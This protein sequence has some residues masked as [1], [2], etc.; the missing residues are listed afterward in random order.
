MR[1]RNPTLALALLALLLVPAGARADFGLAP[2]KATVTTLNRDG[3]I[4]LQAGSHPYSFNLHFELNTDASGISEGGAAR[5]VIVDLPAGLIGN[6]RAVPT[7]P[8]QKFEG[9]VAKCPPSTQVGVLRGVLPGISEAVGPLYNLV[10]P[11][12]TAAQLGFTS[13]TGLESLQS[14]SLRP[15]DYGVRVR[16]SDLSTEVTS[17]TAKIWGTPADPGHTPERGPDQSGGIP[18]DAPLLPFLTLPRSCQG[19]PAVRISVDSALNPGV[20]SSVSVPTLDKGG[21][22][23]SLAGCEMVP[24]APKIL[25]GATTTSADSASGL[26]FSLQL[27][28]QGL[29]DPEARAESEPVKT[30]VALPAGITANPAAAAGLGACSQAQYEAARADSGPGEGCPE[31]SKLGTLVARTPLLDEAIEG[32]IYLAAPHANPFNSLLALYIVAAVPERGVSIKQA[33]EVHAD[34]V[35]GQLTT[36]FDNLPPL[37]YSSFTVR[38]REGPR[39]PLITPQACGTYT[40]TAKLYPFSDP[41][42]ATERTAPFTITSGAGGGACAASEA[43]LPNTPTLAAGT[44]LPIAGAYSPFT[45]RVTRQDGEQR[46]GSLST[47]LPPGLLGRLA[48]IPRCSEAEIAAA[49]ARGFEGGGA[50]ELASPSCPAAS[51][52]GEVSAGAGAGPS[53]YVVN[54]KAYLAGPYKGGPLSFVI[55]TPAVAG[56]FDLGAVVVRAGIDVDESNAQITVRSDPLPRILHGLV[57]DLRSISVDVDRNQFT[58]N[59]TSCE[60]K[61]VSGEVVSLA[62][63][64]AALQ[65]RFQVGACEALGFKPKLALKLKGGTKRGGHPTL[66]GTYRSREGDAN[67]EGLA[68]RLPRSAFL[69][70]A[71][72]KTICTRVQYAANG[73]SG[74]GC[75]AGSVYGKA[76]AFTPLLEEPLEGP[77][78]LRSS[79]N[80]LPD[81]VASL[82][83]LVDVE[84]VARIDSKNGGIRATFTKLPDA[85]LSKVVVQM[86]GAKKGLIVNSTDLCA[87]KHRADARFGAHN[88]KRRTIRPVVEA[89]GCGKTR[90]REPGRMR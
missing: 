35:S 14:A 17:V 75:P 61:A 20:F 64:A 74:G 6:P 32:S 8:R 30:E 36:T 83:G 18:S 56:P 31:S 15:G 65:N 82:H 86:Q 46:F 48:G 49:T 73:G 88:G 10:A 28:N 84:A 34:P 39:A 85:P 52:V 78:Y 2:G 3:T 29:L 26:Q 55:L 62:G 81:F 12:G 42:S 77:V 19:S 24:F 76:R 70:Q 72:I 21:N 7:C 89:S 53:P 51:R 25:A 16:A 63:M 80:N 33:G 50:L 79:N 22:E 38:L 45:F 43:G 57:L 68:L 23:V 60:Q 40:T 66:T 41:A 67:L 44:S 47:T 13:V 54:G 90:N 5:T 1:R 4:D 37:P 59:P 11:P 87:A 69:D 27:P 58:L 71:H 9:G